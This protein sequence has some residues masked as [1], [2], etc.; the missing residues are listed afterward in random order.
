MKEELITI[1]VD[2]LKDAEK[3]MKEFVAE[4]FMKFA[5]ENIQEINE[6]YIIE[7]ELM[8]IMV[9]NA[10]AW[11]EDEDFE[12]DDLHKI[13]YSMLLDEIHFSVD[14]LCSYIS[15]P[16]T[17][18]KEFSMTGENDLMK[19]KNLSEHGLKDYVKYKCQLDIY[20]ML[21]QDPDYDFDL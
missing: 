11:I 5:E 3:A 21:L 8:D 2:E 6:K 9:D 12:V 7:P 19:C 1:S 17:F 15:D 16:I 14:E 20:L 10:R 13:C 4:K 18:K